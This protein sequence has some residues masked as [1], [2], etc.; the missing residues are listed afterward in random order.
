MAVLEEGTA[1]LAEGTA[2]LEEGTA[3]LE[4]GTAVLE[5]VEETGVVADGSGGNGSAG[6]GSAG[7][8]GGESGRKW[9]RH[10]WIMATGPS[11][12]RHLE[13]R[14]ITGMQSRVTHRL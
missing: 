6:D 3:V 7:N 14:A 1:V 11:G 10:E 9:R 5:E 12:E 13:T 8:D 2:V 4:E